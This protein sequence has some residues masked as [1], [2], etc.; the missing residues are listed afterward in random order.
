MTN[1][2]RSAKV[3]AT[4]RPRPTATLLRPQ[5][6]LT[7]ITLFGDENTGEI[8]E[9]YTKTLGILRIR[10]AC[11][12]DLAKLRGAT[13]PKNR[14][15]VHDG[16]LPA[17]LSGRLL[18]LRTHWHFRAELSATLGD[19]RGIPGAPFDLS[20]QRRYELSRA[21]IDRLILDA[22]GAVATASS[23]QRLPRV[24]V[25]KTTSFSLKL[26]KSRLRFP[27]R[28]LHYSGVNAS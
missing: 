9:L 12:D 19:A 1:R 15:F 18:A 22:D 24:H 23:A 20:R 3:R 7:V 21:G 27:F 14:I 6:E 5:T 16:C 25:M 13:L 28:L 26:A 4:R 8:F 17:S 11:S 2:K 10:I